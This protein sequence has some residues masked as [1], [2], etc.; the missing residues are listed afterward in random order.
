[1]RYC[2]V[3]RPTG[4]PLA[5]LLYAPVPAELTAATRNT[6]AVPLVRPVTVALVAVDVPSANVLHVEPES[7]ENCTT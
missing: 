7:L 3:I 2:A 1:M 4:V 6:Y 5:V